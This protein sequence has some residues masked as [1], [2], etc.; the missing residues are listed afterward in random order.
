M[1][2]EYCHGLTTSE[3]SA[4]SSSQVYLN[5]YLCDTNGTNAQELAHTDNP[6]VPSAGPSFHG[7]N[8]YDA[9]GPRFPHL[10]PTIY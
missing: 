7:D 9:V 4:S 10:A 8:V 2:G 5:V 3:S 6:S 1:S